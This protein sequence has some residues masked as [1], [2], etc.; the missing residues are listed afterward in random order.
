MVVF[1]GFFYF[2]YLNLYVNFVIFVFD[3]DCS[4]LCG[5][6]GDEV[7]EL[8]YIFCVIFCQEFIFDCFFYIIIDDDFIVSLKQ[9]QGIK[10]G[11]FGIVLN[12]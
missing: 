3:V 5:F 8:V 9:Y 11:E 1:F 10:V 4:V 2:F 7:E 6:I 12:W